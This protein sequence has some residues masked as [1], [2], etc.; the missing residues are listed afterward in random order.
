MSS[1]KV[2]RKTVYNA[3]HMPKMLKQ[4]QEYVD[5]FRQRYNVPALSV[6]VWHK[7]KLYQASG[8]VLNVETGVEATTDSI[9][10]IASITKVFTASLISQLV[11]EGRVKLDRPVKQYLRDFQLAD[12]YLSDTITVA[13]LLDHTS[14]IPGDYFGNWSYTQPNALAR[15]IDRCSLLGSVHPPGERYSYSNAAYVIAG[16]LIEVALGITWYDAIEERIFKPLGMTQSVVHPSQVVRY[17][18]AMGHESDPDIKEQWRLT[19]HCYLPI[20]TAP[21]GAVM[22]MSASDLIKF[23]RA[24]LNQGRTETGEQWLSPESAE[25][26]QQPRIA[27]PPYSYMFGTGWGLGW[28][29][30]EADGMTIVGHGGAGMGQKSLL[31]FFP[32][33]QLSIAALHNGSSGNLLPDLLQDLAAELVGIKLPIAQPNTSEL[34][35]P[36]LEKFIGS[37][38]SI[39][40]TVRL[41]ID[42][43]ELTSTFT[44]KVLGGTTQYQT[45]WIEGSSFITY[46]EDG[47]RAGAITLL[48]MDQRGIPRYLYMMGRLMP[49]KGAQ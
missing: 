24:H 8:G 49:R 21:C 17:R 3:T 47:A 33:Q 44:D 30:I 39:G 35:E 48:E 38:E 20:A 16:R 11:D 25:L 29:L 36:E 46:S 28:Q 43:Q 7:D 13:Q 2:A 32:E 23:A 18:V 5:Q 6:A 26:M 45:K 12:P 15:Y 22:T 9:F 42:G 14:G 37:Y 27:L 1:N 4:F 19:P 40:A 41:A 31:Y 34:S 10:Q